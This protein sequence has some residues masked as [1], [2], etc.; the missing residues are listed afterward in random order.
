MTVELS[1]AEFRD[2]AGPKAERV[3]VELARELLGGESGTRP[4]M[5]GYTGE[6]IVK[7]ASVYHLERQP[8]QCVWVSGTTVADLIGKA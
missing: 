8:L 1:E 4:R 3:T 2:V 6:H 5:Y 7:L